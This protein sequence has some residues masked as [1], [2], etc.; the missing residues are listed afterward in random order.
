MVAGGVEESAGRV[1]EP[2]QDG[3]RLRYCAVE[4]ALV[5]IGLVEG[6]Q[7]QPNGGVILQETRRGPG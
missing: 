2:C 3:L 5:E 1:D 7:A 6:E 4:P